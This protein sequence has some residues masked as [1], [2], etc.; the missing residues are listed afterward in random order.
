MARRRRA[1]PPVFRPET[2]AEA[3]LFLQA[4]GGLVASEQGLGTTVLTPGGQWLDCSRLSEMEGVQQ[5]GGRMVTGLNMRHA[6]LA[7]ASLLR[8]KALCLV[9][10][11]EANPHWGATLLFDLYAHPWPHTVGALAILDAEVEMASLSPQGKVERT[12]EPWD[13]ALFALHEK[14][15]LP[16][17]VRFAAWSGAV[18]SA[19]VPLSPLQGLQT[20]VEAAYVHLLLQGQP[21]R[22]RR[23][24]I[25][26]ITAEHLPLRLR[27]A[28]VC[29]IEHS[30]HP[31]LLERCAATGHDALLRHWQKD[32]PA[33]DYSVNPTAHLLRLALDRAVARARRQV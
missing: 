21:L 18:G 6:A 20:P 2:L 32:H 24:H 5:F 26:L 16:L 33:V 14:P 23:A 4:E 27:Q 10:A 29:L 7:T 8:Q 9:E 12:W 30:P 3:L 11:C 1:L 13:T 19:Y 28:E 25:G 31:T 15:R 17:A 22:V